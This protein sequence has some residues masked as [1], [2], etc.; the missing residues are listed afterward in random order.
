MAMRTMD[1]WICIHPH[2]DGIITRYFTDELPGDPPIPPCESP[3]RQVSARHCFTFLDFLRPEK[4]A[5]PSKPARK[6]L[7][8][9]RGIRKLLR[10]VLF[11]RV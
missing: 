9:L 1:R 4:P 10:E 5:L 2:R 8:L 7:A 6:R 3:L 11:S